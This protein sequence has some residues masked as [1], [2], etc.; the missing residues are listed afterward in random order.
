MRELR[1]VLPFVAFVSVGTYFTNGGDHAHGLDTSAWFALGAAA[2]AAGSAALARR[3]PEAALVLAGVFA[4]GYFLLGG[5]NGPIYLTGVAVTFACALWWPTR[6]WV[7]WALVEVLLVAAGI[8]LWQLGEGG[9]FIRVLA[10]VGV[11]SAA[12]AIGARIRD[13]RES[14]AERAR[15]AATEE[16]LRMAQDLHD[17]VGHGLAVIAMQAGVALHVLDSDPVAARASLLAIR[18]TS[19]ESLEALR[20]E[21]SALQPGQQAPTRAPRRGLADLEV[22]LDRVRSG[23]LA[24]RLASTVSGGLST[25]VDETAYVVVQEA[26]TNVLRHA[27]ATSARVLVDDEAGEL[28]VIVDDDG[29]G[30]AVQEGMGIGGMRAR[31]EGL[32]GTLEVGPTDAGFRVRATLPTVGR[33]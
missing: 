13:S 23:G 29:E 28:L 12:G 15:L 6:R 1:W 22:L 3:L 21:L 4:G 11:T 31:V 14:R 18:D 8:V 7:P 19:R 9:S 32:G 26:L 20:A 5:E 17:G 24:V 16:Q 33:S 25:A 10:L 27:S 30:G 2:L